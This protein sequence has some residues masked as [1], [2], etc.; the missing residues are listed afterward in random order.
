ML[1]IQTIYFSTLTKTNLFSNGIKII[2]YAIK[3]ITKR[4]NCKEIFVRI[5]QFKNRKRV[6][7]KLLYILHHFPYTAWADAGAETAAYAKVFINS[8]FI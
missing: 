1:Y 6:F 3:Y 8:I 4:K 7:F 5:G 2:L